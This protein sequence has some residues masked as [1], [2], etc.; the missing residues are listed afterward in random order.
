MTLDCHGRGRDFESRRPRHIFQSLTSPAPNG[1]GDMRGRKAANATSLPRPRSKRRLLRQVRF[2]QEA[3][4]QDRI[5]QS[6]LRMTLRLRRRLQVF[7]RD[8]KV[9]MSV[10]SRGL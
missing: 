2:R 1:S 10:D 3:R 9:G 5:D 7:V 6:V 8:V 4:S